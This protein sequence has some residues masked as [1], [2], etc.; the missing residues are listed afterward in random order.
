MRNLNE[1]PAGEPRTDDPAG[2]DDEGGDATC[3]AQCAEETIVSLSAHKTRTSNEQ[4]AFLRERADLTSLRATGAGHLGG[5]SA[6][7][8]GN[9]SVDDSPA[10]LLSMYMAI[11]AGLEIESQERARALSDDARVYIG[12]N[13]TVEEARAA[14]RQTYFRGGN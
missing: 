11:A 10:V 12:A 9:C 8:D 1:F 4:I 3:A 7:G 5:G 2:V 6:D 13:C 14:M